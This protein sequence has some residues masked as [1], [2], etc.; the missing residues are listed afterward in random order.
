MSD[1]LDDLLRRAAQTLDQ[2]T[3]GDYFDALPDRMLARLDEDGDEL[4]RARALRAEGGA[5]SGSD[6]AANAPGP[7]AAGDAAA[8]SAGEAAATAS[9]A[10]AAPA[11]RRGRRTRTIAAVIGL[12]VAAA[13]AI[14]IVVSVRDRGAGETG[15][16][17][18]AGPPAAGAPLRSGE[19]GPSPDVPVVLDASVA[20]DERAPEKP[21]APDRSVAPDKPVAPEVPVPSKTGKRRGRDLTKMVPG[22]TG[23]AT[24]NVKPSKTPPP[25]KGKR[26]VEPLD[27]AESSKP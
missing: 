24:K 10:E 11:H 7:D 4:A 1:E 3:P 16:T 21:P 27:N 26:A 9:R 20:S 18:P 8:S 23:P 13:A 19:P 14:V 2:Q 22:E 6:A 12:A 17:L 15:A 5:T 25:A